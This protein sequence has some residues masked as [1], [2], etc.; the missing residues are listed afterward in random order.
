MK[1][2]KQSALTLRTSS[3]RADPRTR[4]APPPQPGPNRAPR[5]RSALAGFAVALVGL[6][7]LTGLAPDLRAQETV[8]VPEL[9][10]YQ[11]VLATLDGTRTYTNGLYDIQFKIWNEPTATAATNL[12][13]GQQYSLYVKDGYFN[14]V[15][16]QGGQAL[17]NVTQF[18]N[19]RDVFRTASGKTGRY[20]GLTVKQ[21][22]NHAA[23]PNPVECTPRQQL[24]TAA[25]AFQSQYAQYA[26]ES[27][28]KFYAD[29]GLTVSGDTLTANAGLTVA[30][31]AGLTVTGAKAVLQIGLQVAGNAWFANGLS[32]S[33]APAILTGG[34]DVS[35]TTTLRGTTTNKGATTF[36]STATFNGAATFANT[37]TVNG[38]ATFG[39]TATVNGAAT[40]N[41]NST[42]AKPSTFNNA[43]TVN[44]GTNGMTVKGN[45]GLFNRTVTKMGRILS[46]ADVIKISTRDCD[47]FLII[48]GYNCNAK[49]WLDFNGDGWGEL[50]PSLF[51]LTSNSDTHFS[52]VPLNKGGQAEVQATTVESSGY[53]DVWWMKLGQ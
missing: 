39:S 32:V 28:N 41:N 18:N 9:L 40:F 4:T 26:N 15:L 1:L 45:V 53:I 11:G 38:A 35:G 2:S 6:A 19:L 36:D 10:N 49:V 12:L 24:L 29:K 31:S 14:V 5:Q 16:G 46:T 50:Y 22:E 25:F 34:L 42:F 30:G 33:N 21:D 13:W 43:V 20:L 27:T 47:G 37:A 23:V 52:S 7:L 17:T 48:A 3:L 44:A 51:F 8:L